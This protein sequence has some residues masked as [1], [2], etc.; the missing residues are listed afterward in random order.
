MAE[1][2]V[3]RLLE[4]VGSGDGT[5]RDRLLERV[6]GELRRLAAGRMRRERPGHTLQPTAL[7]HEAY[8][9]L[10]RGE[11]RFENRAHFFGAA[12]EAMRR[13]LV[14]HAR[15]KSARK[16]GGDVRQVTFDDLAVASSEPETDVL[17]LDEALQALAAEDERLARVVM[18]RYF[19]G[20]GIEETATILGSSPATVKRD[21]VYAR[22][23]L[24]EHMT[25]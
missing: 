22:A 20:L 21:W 10:V 16:R 7:V 3:T 18:L 1:S 23:W 19:V 4:A 12:A 17:A 25:R 24:R 6:Y 2:D 8:L 11:P 9:R 15:V 13:V 14:E 5:A